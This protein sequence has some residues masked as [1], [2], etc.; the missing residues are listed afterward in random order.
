MK[1]TKKGLLYQLMQKGLQRKDQLSS[2]TKHVHSVQICSAQQ[3][4]KFCCHFLA[5]LSFILNDLYLRTYFHSLNWRC[6]AQWKHVFGKSPYGLGA[7]TVTFFHNP[8]LP[9]LGS[10]ESGEHLG[11]YNL[12]FHRCPTQGHSF[13]RTA[14]A[15][16][17]RAGGGREKEEQHPQHL[18]FKFSYKHTQ[19]TQTAA[20]KQWFA[21]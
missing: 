7:E 5:F 1:I 13:W 6:S 20:L 3:F 14:N 15:V 12:F 9:S 4:G 8:F 16:V 19:E 17:Q 21:V 18:N 11:D 10:N 2:S